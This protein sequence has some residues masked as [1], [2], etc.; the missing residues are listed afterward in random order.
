MAKAGQFKSEKLPSDQAALKML[1]LGRVDAAPMER[2]VAC[3]LLKANYSE[4]EAAKLSPHPKL[5]TETFTTHLMLPRV[6]EESAARL[7]DFNAGLKKLRASGEYAKLLAK[8]SC[9]A[10]WQ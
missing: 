4:A 1:L 5:M 6:R 8:T 3:D 9:P 7:A 2:N 10:S